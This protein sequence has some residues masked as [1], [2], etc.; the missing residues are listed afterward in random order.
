MTL[1]SKQQIQLLIKTDRRQQWKDLKTR[2]KAAIAKAKLDF[3]LKLGPALDKYQ[4]QVD[5]VEN[6]AKTAELQS[7]QVQAVM[8]AAAPLDK[9]IKSYQDKVKLLEEPARKELSA[10]LKTIDADCALWL[11][12]VLSSPTSLGATASQKAAAGALCTDLSQI[13][14]F[15]EITTT[16]GP[17]AQARYEAAKPVPNKAAA[18]LASQLVAAAR[19][20]GPLAHKLTDQCGGAAEGK[21]Y[22][23]FKAQAEAAGLAIKRFQKASAA[24][25]DAWGDA[26][27]GVTW[28]SDVDA[29]ALQNL[30]KSMNGLLTRL[31][32]NIGKLQ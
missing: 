24:F 9:I 5:K 22:P 11:K 14:G 10:L 15:A 21:N 3:D 23:L 32:S 31:L 25:H 2:H 30:H 12:Y 27:H 29:S 17:R 8:D 1:T 7:Y 16:R 19:I 28:T 4:V 26:D 18:A 13:R 20:A 6:I